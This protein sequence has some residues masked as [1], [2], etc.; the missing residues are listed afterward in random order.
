[1]F[2]TFTTKKL[3]QVIAIGAFAF[4]LTAC[5]NN[6]NETGNAAN[7][8][9]TEQTANN[10]ANATNAANTTDLASTEASDTRTL[11][12]AMGHEVVVPANP[13]RVIASYLEDNLVAL[14]IKPVAQWSVKDGKSIQGYL[15]GELNGIPTIGYDLP[16]EAVQSFKP[17]L[18]IMDSASMVEGGKYEQYNQIAPTYVIGTEVNNDWR[19]ELLRVGQVF[20]KEDA[21]KQALA[22]YDKKAADAKATIAE[23]VG[24]PSAAAI[25]LVGGKFFM[26]SET[27]S[28]GAVMYGDLGLK[29]PAVVKEISASATGNWSEISLEK[30]VELDAD[31]LF[32]VNSDS[33]DGSTAL[34]E[35]LWKSIPAVKAGNVFEFTPNESWLY[36]GTIAN[37]QIIDNIL[38]S[39]VK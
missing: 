19:D 39:I 9:A 18:I 4:T 33:A 15:Q 23:K 3:L 35:A 11:T 8:Q 21:A 31:Y 12:D 22:D 20:G 2:N 37:S 24:N 32:L 14:G 36:T 34:S 7:N 29:V 25:W 30:L 26:V 28:S 16:F 17:D 38:K 13:Q 10:A 27:L 1:M 6:A 5:G